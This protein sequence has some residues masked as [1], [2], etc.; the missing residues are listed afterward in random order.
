MSSF[1]KG[2]EVYLKATVDREADEKHKLLRLMTPD[3]TVVWASPDEVLRAADQEK[4][5]TKS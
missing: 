4:G 1:V 3:G 2:E 5:H